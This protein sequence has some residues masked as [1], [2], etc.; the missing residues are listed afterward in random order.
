MRNEEALCCFGK[1]AEG[2]KFLSGMA[3]GLILDMRRARRGGSIGIGG[4]ERV[5]VGSRAAIAGH[6]CAPLRR[7]LATP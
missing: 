7:A 2:E 6:R 5:A 4:L 1:H 3:S